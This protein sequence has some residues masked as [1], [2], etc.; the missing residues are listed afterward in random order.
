MYWARWPR[1]TKADDGNVRPCSLFEHRAATSFGILLQKNHSP[2]LV[3][4]VPYF[5][6][7]VKIKSLD[8]RICYTNTKTV[9]I[10]KTANAQKMFTKHFIPVIKITHTKPPQ[11][12]QI[13]LH[14]TENSGSRKLSKKWYVSSE[15][16]VRWLNGWIR[17]PSSLFT[18]FQSRFNTFQNHLSHIWRWERGLGFEFL[19]LV[20]YSFCYL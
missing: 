14:K 4:I 11:Q 18:P 10:C 8:L 6:C 19:S 13:S 9:S 7:T 3:S 17:K 5:W 12:K 16:V 20:L 1:K 15:L 2:D